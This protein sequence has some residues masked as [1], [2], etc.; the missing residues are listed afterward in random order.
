[1][2]KKINKTPRRILTASMSLALLISLS[3][4]SGAVN[5]I[6]NLK[7]KAN[8][9]YATSGDYNVSYGELW[10]ELQ[11]NANAVLGEQIT[12][13]VLESYISNI[14]SVINKSYNDLTA[15]EKKSLGLSEDSD[16]ATKEFSELKVS[17]SDR[18]VDYVVQDIYDLAFSKDGYWKAI[19]DL[20]PLKNEVSIEKY[21]DQMYTAH[22]EYLLGGRDQFKNHLVEAW[23]L[24][25]ETEA[26]LAEAKAKY[27]EVANGY[28]DL[29]YPLLAKE[30]LAFDDLQEDIDK[31]LKEDDDEDDDKDGYFTH[32]QFKT[33]LEN[34]YIN[35][36]D[37]NMVMIRFTSEQEFENTLRAFGLKIYNKKFYFVQ[38]GKEISETV[39][40]EKYIDR[41]DDVTTSNDFRNENG[42][43]PIDDK[44][45]I[46]E[47]YIQLYNYVYSGY[48]TPLESNYPQNFN[49]INELRA[50][51][52]KILDDYNTDQANEKFEAAKTKLLSSNNSEVTF[53]SKSLDKI[54]GSLK[55]YVYDTLDEKK[56][57][58]TS[59]QS[60]NGAYYVA[61]K[62]DDLFDNYDDTMTDEEKEKAKAYEKY[63]QSNPDLTSF[64]AM[65]FIKDEKLNPGLY[66]ELLADLKFDQLSESLIT[67]AL[68]EKTKEVSV[69]IYSEPL[70]ISYKKEHPDYSKTLGKPSNKNLLAT[71]KYNKKSY[72]LNI[73]ADT[74]DK[75]SLKDVDGNEIG[76][77]NILEKKLGSTVSIDLLADKIVKNTKAYAEVKKDKESIK[78]YEDYLEMLLVNF[79][80]G[81]LAQQGYDASLGKYNFLMLYFH[82]ADVN[83]IVNDTFL[84]QHAAQKLLTDFSSIELAEFFK[85]YTDIAYKNYFS[86]SGTRLVVYMDKDDDN[87]P[88]EMSTNWSSTT[89][90]FEG[91][92]VTLDYVAKSLILEVYTKL[93][94]SSVSHTDRLNQLVN[95]I[96]NSARVNF[97]DNVIAPENTW[98]KYRSLGLKVKTEEFAAT[99][100]DVEIDINL[101][102]RLYD[103]S[104]GQNEDGSKKYEYFKN[105]EAPSIYME[106]LDRIESVK[107]DNN[108]IVK[109]NDGYNLILVTTGAKKPSAEWKAEKNDDKLL[110]NIIVKYN[111]KY[112]SIENVYNDGKNDNPA[113]E[114]A[115]NL[116]QIR[117]Y[118]IDNAA[119]GQSTLSPASTASALSTF[120]QPVLSRYSSAETQ[121]IIL[122]NFI[123]S[124]TNQNDS[125]EL[126]DVI[127]FPDDNEINTYLGNVIEINQKIVDDYNTVYGDPLT[128]IYPD[129]W[130]NLGE[131]VSKFLTKEGK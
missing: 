109:T 28:K 18:L 123:K 104:R 100:S 61:Y 63:F 76:A 93:S 128:N 126:K 35:K 73:L 119:N 96:N 102:N 33:A 47:L 53:T 87:I 127:T 42:V 95:E 38:D 83:K 4:C 11:W 131:Q 67:T 106:P 64:E 105:G 130:K 86:L 15:D 45:V 113:L 44:R 120:L 46:L 114:G 117:L 65:E 112:V 107:E 94:A 75:N 6:G 10:N 14:N 16:K 103:Y 88:D 118:I 110:E 122:L 124:S 31:A 62:F 56:P 90:T 25:K 39:S 37:L 5:T 30:L 89:V 26:T 125:T 12:N 29:Y 70:E 59:T 99:N 52:K 17:Y 121:R 69:K 34:K 92:S 116:N 108:D 78:Y 71:I 8:D 55:S 13:V 84:V 68:D 49:D 22:H 9:S 129:W 21:I 85:T 97:K 32:S 82:T 77:F 27:L 54:S 19:S 98:A 50:Q 60:A 58:S 74:K 1:M 80:A 23:K 115:L 7:E 20:K 41:Y 51:T 111:D 40:Y 24:D 2:S 57:Y 3:S 72:N 66:D 48:R 79:A 91:E 43:L 81:G 101:K 36:Y